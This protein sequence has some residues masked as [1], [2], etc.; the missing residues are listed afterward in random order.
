MTLL[1]FL[2]S[3]FSPEVRAQTL[4]TAFAPTIMSVPGNVACAVQQPDGKYVLLG[5]FKRTTTGPIGNLVRLNADFTLDQSFNTTV[6]SLQGSIASV[7]V[8][9]TGK[10]LVVGLNTLTL[11]GVSRQDLLRLN[12]DGSPDASFN[13]GTASGGSN[14]SLVVEPLANG[15]LLVGGNFTTYNGMARNKIARLT[16]T[17]DVDAT[18]VPAAFA[19]TVSRLAV[20]RDGKILVGGGLGG[21]VGLRRLNADGTT[22]NTFAAPIITSVSDLI[23]QSDGNIIVGGST[24]AFTGLTSS[25]LVRL[26]PS[27]SLDTSFLTL[28]SFTPF[29]G[30]DQRLLALQA[31]GRL[32]VQTIDQGLVRLNTNGSIDLTFQ[33]PI[34]AR[35]KIY[36]LTLTVAGQLLLGG[37]KF[38]LPAHRCQAAL[39][40][41]DGSLDA[42][43]AP[44][45]LTD[46]R[47]EAVAVQADGAVLIGGS[48]DEINGQPV[49]NLARLTASG[50]LDAAFTP[51]NWLQVNQLMALPTGGLLVTQY[52]KTS[53]PALLRLTSTGALDA[54]FY[55]NP[56]LDRINRLLMQPDGRLLVLAD[57]IGPYTNILPIRLLANGHRDHSFT[58]ALNGNYGF[59]SD[60]TLQP[61]GKVIIVGEFGASNTKAIIRI[62]PNGQ[63]DPSFASL[64]ID[65][66]PDATNVALQPDGK[67]LLIDNFYTR[68]RRLTATGQ[69]DASFS[70]SL[71]PKSEVF[72]FRVQSN[73]RILVGGYSYLL[74]L[75]P[76]GNPDGAF[77]TQAPNSTATDVATTPTGK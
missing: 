46:G 35:T 31:T 33:Q 25:T 55:A 53:Q 71:P 24:T 2:A 20:Q 5:S 6:A 72:A 39:L 42:R 11:A 62:L 69:L 32:V 52:N 14:N 23:L 19:A 54:S 56:S 74:R 7:R 67:I 59:A 3:Q 26:L 12:A 28:L 27:G 22:D 18:F 44:V 75:L 37:D 15:Q 50:S 29:S 30:R 9:P 77:T 76:N 17:G 38:E 66:A 51:P 68:L 61:D 48:F 1:V 40:N 70:A 10:L 73:G 43:F 58:I 57:T 41:A 49:N 45:L 13:A 36:W 60:A 8:L 21:G 65:D 63:Q 4:D 16:A 47:V 64:S 34:A